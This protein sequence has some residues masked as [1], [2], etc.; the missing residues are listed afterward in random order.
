MLY[1]LTSFLL[2]FSVTANLLFILQSLA[3]KIG[4]VDSPT[5]RKHH[6]NKIP[7]IGG[8]AMFCG[9]LLTVLLVEQPLSGLRSLFAGAAILIIVGIFDDFR[10]LSHRERFVAEMIAALLVSIGGGTVLYDFGAIGFSPNNV[11]L[12]M[13]A[14]PLTIFSIVGV[15][16]AL[17][18]SDGI[19]GLAGGLVL[20]ALLT[21]ALTTWLAG[22]NKELCLLLLLIA[23]VIGFLGFNMRF[24]WQP[25]ALVFMGDAGSMFLG[26]MLAWFLIELSQ[27]EQRVI[28]PVTALWILALPLMD[29]VSIMVRRI[30]NGRS[31]FKADREHLHYFLL[32]KGFT[33][34]QT[35]SIMLGL[36]AVFALTGLI[37]LYGGISENVMFWGFVGLF[38]VHLTTMMVI[39]KD[40]QKMI[41]LLNR[42]LKNLFGSVLKGFFKS[43]LKRCVFLFSNKKLF[44]S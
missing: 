28:T 6:Q 21:L 29:T 42:F 25:R 32:E 7:L 11:E 14:L 12:G 20:V 17:N 16:N 10:E 27:G 22:F 40:F 38:V 43:G 4:L 33:V 13:F 2:A 41:L 37:G 19:D 34:F 5:N 1:Y 23:V 35:L 31:P 15:I 9:F 18:M 30:L 26:F 44:S 36:A 24:P 39:W 3:I 8:I